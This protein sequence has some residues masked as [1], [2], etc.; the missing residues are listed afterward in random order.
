[1]SEF[2]RYLKQFYVQSFGLLI[3]LLASLPMLMLLV[4]SLGYLA[5]L[6]WRLFLMGFK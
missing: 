6:L 1:M 4:I 5:S 2:S 3:T